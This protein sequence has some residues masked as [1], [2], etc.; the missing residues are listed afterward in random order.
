MERVWRK[1]NPLVLL[2]VSC[3]T[4]CDSMDCTPP[5]FS[6]RG[7]TGWIFRVIKVD[8]RTTATEIYQRVSDNMMRLS[9]SLE[10]RPGTHHQYC[11]K[12]HT[13]APRCVLRSSLTVGIARNMPRVLDD[14]WHWGRSSECEE[15]RHSN[16]LVL[17]LRATDSAA[18]VPQGPRSVTAAWE[19]MAAAWLWCS[20][21]GQW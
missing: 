10:G 13:L 21:S 15:T 6:V 3:L 19:E 1:G 18:V 11:L 2:R 14:P 20:L 7:W 8:I 12:A 4:L 5:G 17:L 16:S 9:P